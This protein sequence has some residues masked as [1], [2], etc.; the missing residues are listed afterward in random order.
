MSEERKHTSLLN[1]EN[2]SMASFLSSICPMDLKA[3]TRVCHVAL[4]TSVPPLPLASN[5][6]SRR[7][8]GST[9]DTARLEGDKP[10]SGARLWIS[11][12]I[13]HLEHIMWVSFFKTASTNR[14]ILISSGDFWYMI[15]LSD[16]GNAPICESDGGLFFS[17]L[18]L[19]G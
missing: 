11:K 5:C 1:S 9:S 3:T 18:E 4:Y 7:P 2:I 15:L 14:L 13:E 8:S 16:I 12:R 19:L 6:L 17:V 10:M